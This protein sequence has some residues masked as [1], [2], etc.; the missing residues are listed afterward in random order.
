MNRFDHKNREDFELD[1]I[2]R[3]NRFTS[4]KFLGR[5]RYDRSEFPTLR[6][7]ID[8]AKA[9]GP[10]RMIYAVTAEGRSAM[11]VEK[12]WDDCLRMRGEV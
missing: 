8:H 6:E 1:V 11:I 5:G 12:I 7:A 3:A 9:N 10:R 2:R 4:V